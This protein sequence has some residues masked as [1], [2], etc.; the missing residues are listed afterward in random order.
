MPGFGKTIAGLEAISGGLDS[1]KSKAEATAPVVARTRQV[2]TEAKENL[3]ELSRMFELS[4]ATQNDFSKDFELDMQRVRLGVISLDEY[5]AKWGDASIATEDGF[6][7]IRESFSGADFGQYRQQI[8]ELINDITTGAAE[9]GDIVKFLK[10]NA[11]DLAKGLINVL[12]LFQAGKASLEDVQRAL[13]ATKAAFPGAD[14]DALTEAIRNAL[15]GGDLGG[16]V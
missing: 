15:L 2:V 1:V 10:E 12:E 6:R 16:Q 4:Q 11:G 3:D 8:Q 7:T 14:S 13:D 5:I 9:V